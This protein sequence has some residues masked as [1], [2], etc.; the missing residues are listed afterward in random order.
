[1]VNAAIGGGSMGGSLE[2]PRQRLGR[3]LPGI[4]E[5][6]SRQARH[7]EAQEQRFGALPERHFEHAALQ[8]AHRGV[9]NLLGPTQA[10]QG[11]WLGWHLW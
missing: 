7:E 4:D 2:H 6:P 11:S 9:G 3:P 5:L 8:V 1:M 10:E